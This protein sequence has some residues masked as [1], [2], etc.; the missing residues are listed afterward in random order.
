MRTQLDEVL[1]PNF[2][3]SEF[4]CPCDACH[5]GRPSIDLVNK[6]QVLS[7][8]TKLPIRITSGIRCEL[9]NSAVGGEK[10]SQHLYG[11]AVDVACPDSN[12]RFKI[13]QAAFQIGFTGIGIAKN[14][15]H[16]DVGHT[17]ATCW[18][19]YPK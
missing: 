8:L 6:L 16:L 10:D 12:T 2:R 3:L 18:T 17:S 15:I 13:M 5:G 19:Y 7:D 9:H 1:S 4:Q 11:N 14:Y